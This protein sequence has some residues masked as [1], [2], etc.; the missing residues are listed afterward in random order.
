L[1][2]K[3]REYLGTPF[4]AGGRVKGV[5]VDCGGLLAC[6]MQDLGH[7]VSA[8]PISSP[9]QALAAILAAASQR[10][11]LVWQVPAPFDGTVLRTGDFLVFSSMALPGHCG[12]LTGEGTFIHAYDSPSVRRVVETPLDERW[13][14]RIHA[15]FRIWHR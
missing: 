14:A 12:L 13:Q 10:A 2:S 3:A 9:G 15:V 6:V 8:Q 7:E 1:I 5:G 4:H 11:E